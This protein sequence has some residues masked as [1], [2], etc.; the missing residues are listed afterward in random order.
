MLPKSAIEVILYPSENLIR[1]IENDKVKTIYVPDCNDLITKLINIRWDE[2]CMMIAGDRDGFDLD[3]NRYLV[4]ALYDSVATDLK[5]PK[6]QTAHMKHVLSRIS[7]D[8]AA[9]FMRL[10]T[11]AII[12]N[13]P[14][15]TCHVAEIV[16]VHF[17]YSP[18]TKRTADIIMEVCKK[19]REESDIDTVANDIVVADFYCKGSDAKLNN[20]YFKAVNDLYAVMYKTGILQKISFE[21]HDYEEYTYFAC[22]KNDVIEIAKTMPLDNIDF[23]LEA[24]NKCDQCA[25]TR[26]IQPGISMVSYR[27]ISGCITK[28]RELWYTQQFINEAVEFLFEERHNNG[29]RCC[30]ELLFKLMSF[31]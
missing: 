1:I 22:Y 14:E 20:P 18:E 28:I 19:L 9:D 10:C 6:S 30:I 24:I 27:D 13:V 17:G 4:A 21:Y 11:N 25:W 23:A 5:M 29:T 8:N 26:A 15:M 7:A 12:T 2:I 31:K 16:D 3:V